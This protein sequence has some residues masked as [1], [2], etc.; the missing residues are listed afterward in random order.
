MTIAKQIEEPSESVEVGGEL[1]FVSLMIAIA[2]HKRLVILL[3]LVVSVL[4]LVISL[5]LPKIYKASTK[6]LPPQAAQSSAGALLAQLG[7]VAGMAAGV[8][9]LKNPSDVYIGML[10]SRTVAD[11]LI[12]QFDLKKRY[13]T[14]SQEEARQSLEANTTIV[15]GKDGLI[16]IDVED[17]DQ[18]LVAP[19]ANAY[20]SELLRLTRVLA[21]T[22]AGQRRIFF[23]R[24][25]EQA[26]DNLA[27]AETA[28]KQG[29]DTRGV[30]NVDSESRAVMET[31]A[32]LRAQVSTKEIEL[33]SMKPF[34][35]PNHPDFLRVSEELSSLRAELGKLENGRPNNPGAAAAGSKDQA[36]LASIQLLRDLKY[37]Q[38]LYELLAK[39]YEVARLDEAKDPSVIQV[40]DPAVDPERK[41]KP[42]RAVI[43]LSAGAAALFLAIFLAFAAEAKRRALASSGA[44]RQW[45]ELKRHLRFR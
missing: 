15:T 5:M 35:T 4:A 45:D 41:F 38:M 32:R 18:K 10:R 9:G 6:L 40:L 29:L 21:V 12:A 16:Q 22:E 28:L 23:E 42:K 7:G 11:R 39:Q 14:L 30:I 17:K 26:K 27:K 37:Y 20:V 33:N 31:V 24:Q 34:V 1:S 19:I 3:P 2:R 44:A 43:V 8:A 36:G 13:S 25:L